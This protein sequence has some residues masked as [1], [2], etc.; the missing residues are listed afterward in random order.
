MLATHSSK[1]GGPDSRVITLARLAWWWYRPSGTH[2]ER[3]DQ[4]GSRKRAEPGHS[5]SSQHFSQSFSRLPS[6]CKKLNT[7]GYP[8]RFSM[9]ATPVTSCGCDLP[10]S[11]ISAKSVGKRNTR[12]R[13]INVLFNG[14]TTEAACSLSVH[15]IL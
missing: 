4:R 5:L 13:H 15:F 6:L 3:G 12:A 8:Y 14:K 9:T 1:L 11:V 10:V 2:T 7:G